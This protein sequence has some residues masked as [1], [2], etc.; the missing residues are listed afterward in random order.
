MRWVR[1]SRVW[2]VGTESTLPPG[3]P[4]VESVGSWTVENADSWTFGRL[5][6]D[7]SRGGGGAPLADLQVIRS[8]LQLPYTRTSLT[9]L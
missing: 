4:C 9:G 8:L 5:F 3:G 2:L 1:Y 7:F 6:L